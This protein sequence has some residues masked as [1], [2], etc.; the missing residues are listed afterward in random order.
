MPMAGA[1]H[2]SFG[3][4]EPAR[5]GRVSRR[6]FRD[7]AEAVTLRGH[8]PV[9]GAE[10]PLGAEAAATRAVRGAS[11]WTLADERDQPASAT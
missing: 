2:D 1:K 3:R 10:P 6:R 5:S 9:V 8:A 4:D 7:Y 11:A